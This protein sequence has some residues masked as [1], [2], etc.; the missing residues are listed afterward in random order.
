M[1]KEQIKALV[2]KLEPHFLGYRADCERL[3]NRFGME[4]LFGEDWR[5]KTE[6]TALLAS[7]YSY[8]KIGCSFE[9]P[10]PKIVA[11]IKRRLLPKYYEKF[12]IYQKEKKRARAK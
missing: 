5:G 4:I 1:D 12:M 9:K 11:D 7:H 6:V 3:K 2:K 10:I 8:K